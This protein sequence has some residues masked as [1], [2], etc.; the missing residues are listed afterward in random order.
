MPHFLHPYNIICNHNGIGTEKN[1]EKAI[2]WYEKGAEKGDKYA[3]YN[4]G[5]IYKNEEEKRDDN[6]SFEWYKKAAEAGDADAMYELGIIY[7]INYQNRYEA[8][9]WYLKANQAGN[10]K[11]QKA[12][13][14]L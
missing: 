14:R 2:E 6:K 5:F 4:L 13:E 9:Q 8:A 10:Q 1:I 11:A 12:F 3:Y 7:E